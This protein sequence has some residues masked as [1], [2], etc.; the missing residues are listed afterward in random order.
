MAPRLPV[1]PEMKSVWPACAPKS[2]IACRAV[3]AVR[4]THAASSMER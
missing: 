4:G 3:S 2:S 1:P